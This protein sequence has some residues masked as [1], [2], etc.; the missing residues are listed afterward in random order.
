MGEAAHRQ[1]VGNEADADAGSNGHVS[2]VVEAA[3]RAPSHF[4]ECSAV[5]VGIERGRRTRGALQRAEHIRVGPVRFRS[6][7]YVSVGLRSSIKIDGSE[8]CNPE[9]LEGVAC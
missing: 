4:S 8:A 2:E 3:A 6:L 1:T 7:G 5:D 9:S